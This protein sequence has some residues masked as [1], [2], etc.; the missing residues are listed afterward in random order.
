MLFIWILCCTMSEYYF[1]PVNRRSKGGLLILSPS[2][3]SSWSG[4][5][6]VAGKN[7]NFYVKKSNQVAASGRFRYDH[8]GKNIPFVWD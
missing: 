8:A 6:C 5:L 4:V 7:V 2:R 3:T 1:F